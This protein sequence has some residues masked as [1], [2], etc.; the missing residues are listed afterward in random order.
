[1]VNEWYNQTLGERTC[2][3]LRDN[4]FIA[5]YF[6]ERAGAITYISEHIQKDLRVGFGGSVTTA[7]LGLHDIAKQN[8]AI[9]IDHHQP[10][11]SD[12]EKFQVMREQLLSD[13]FICSANAITEM[14]EIVNLDHI[15]NRAGALIFGP[16]KKIVVAG[17]NKVV[18]N[19]DDAWERI[20]RESAPK[21]NKRLGKQNPCVVA[22][23]CV[24][25]QS[26][27]RIC[28]SY[29]TLKK[30]PF[31]G[32]FHVVLIGESIGL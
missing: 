24:N 11:L 1:M 26:E 9:I 4:G 18:A 16:K 31:I 19:L 2:D 30:R 12:E 14:G 32:A 6:P 23:Q 15:G 27:T 21:N 13:V 3:A 22:G 10:G 28:R 7:E 17:I 20:A 25:C 5:E 8:G 29:V